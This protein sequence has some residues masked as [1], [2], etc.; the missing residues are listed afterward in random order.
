[1]ASETF[2]RKTFLQ[3]QPGDQ[4][5]RVQQYT[6]R[7]SLHPRQPPHSFGMFAAPLLAKRQWISQYIPPSAPETRNNRGYSLPPVPPRR[8]QGRNRTPPRSAACLAALPP[9]RPP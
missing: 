4:P 5:D 7:Q 9:S 6:A 3:L 8:D 1:M 2:M